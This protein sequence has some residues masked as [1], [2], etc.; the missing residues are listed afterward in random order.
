MIDWV[1]LFGN[2]L[3]I[4]GLAVALAGASY[5]SWESSLVEDKFLQVLNRRGYSL[6]FAASGLL[7]CTGL[8]VTSFGNWRFLVWTVLAFAF[9]A[10]IF[11]SFDIFSSNKP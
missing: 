9:L 7:F 2:A 3:W 4:L 6:V 1:N 11:I 5:A 10:Y 8:A